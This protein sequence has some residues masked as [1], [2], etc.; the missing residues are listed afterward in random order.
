VVVPVVLHG[1]L[2]AEKEMTLSSQ[3]NKRATRRPSIAKCRFSAVELT[4]SNREESAFL[5]F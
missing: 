5:D 3:G 1:N 4:C 2:L